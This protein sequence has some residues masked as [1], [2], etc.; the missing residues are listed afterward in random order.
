MLTKQA[1]SQ[2]EDLKYKE[3]GDRISRFVGHRN[4]SDGEIRPLGATADINARPNTRRSDM[5]LLSDAGHLSHGVVRPNVP[6]L[7]PLLRFLAAENCYSSEFT[8]ERQ[9]D[10][11]SDL[12]L[13]F[14]E[15]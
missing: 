11:R 5:I 6:C 8:K 2:L 13:S 4:R 3:R 12:R 7:R 9:H 1:R 10:D 15:S 14:I